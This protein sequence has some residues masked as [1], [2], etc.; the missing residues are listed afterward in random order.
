MAK[1][2]KAGNIA[3]QD[4]QFGTST[5]MLQ[6]FLDDLYYPGYTEELHN[7]NPNGY[8]QE[9]NQFSQTYNVR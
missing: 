5:D 4:L 7:T 3:A 1:G 2:Q 9:L 8:T 6:E